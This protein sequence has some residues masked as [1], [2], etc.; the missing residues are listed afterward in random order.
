M[1]RNKAEALTKKQC[2]EFRQLLESRKNVLLQHIENVGAE[3]NYLD[4]SR[5]P[6]LSE[7]AQEEAAA[8]SLKALDERERQ[9]LE[10]INL[11][12]EKMDEGTYGTCDKCEEQIGIARLNILPSVRHCISCKTKMEEKGRHRGSF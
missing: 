11:A 9:E 8:I 7:E 6:E 3:L 1:P 4:Q 12:L 2:N 5:P 10:D